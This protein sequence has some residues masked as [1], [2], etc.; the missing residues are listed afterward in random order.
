LQKSTAY[1]EQAHSAEDTLDKV[2]SADLRQAMKVLSTAGFFLADAD[3]IPPGHF[4]RVET[5]DALIRGKQKPM[6]DVFGIW[7]FQK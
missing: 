2:S 3:H 1:F 4:T 7:P 6:L 5:A